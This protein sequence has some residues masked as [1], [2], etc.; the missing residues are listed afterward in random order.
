M[1]RKLGL[2]QVPTRLIFKR[3][4]ITLIHRRLIRYS[5]SVLLLVLECIIFLMITIRFG[6]HKG[7]EEFD[8]K[9]NKNL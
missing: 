1:V 7:F 2:P 6:F 3:N 8:L 9:K 4:G 5:L